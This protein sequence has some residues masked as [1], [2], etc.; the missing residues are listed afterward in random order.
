[1]TVVTQQSAFVNLFYDLFNGVSLCDHVSNATPFFS[2]ENVVKLHADWRK[3]SMAIFTW[4]F[5]QF[6]DDFSQDFAAFYEL[7]ISLN[8]VLFVLIATISFASLMIRIVIPFCFSG[9]SHS[10]QLS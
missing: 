4:L 6:I 1:M 8:F 2:R 7:L 3:D 9:S 5:F 10:K